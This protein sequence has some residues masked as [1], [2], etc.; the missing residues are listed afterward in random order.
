MHLFHLSLAGDAKDWYKC[1]EPNSITTWAQSKTTFLKRFYPMARMQDWC[2]KIASFTQKDDENLSAIGSQF[3]RMI[4]ACPHHEYEENH[5]NTFFYDGL[6]DS[7]KALL[8]LAV[9][10]QL[11]KAPCNQV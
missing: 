3:K 7:T 1:L 11:S 6:N 5:L 10:G 8:D 9:G 2:K 4:R